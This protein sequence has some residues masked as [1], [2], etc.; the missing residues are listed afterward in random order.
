MTQCTQVYWIKVA[1][2]KSEQKKRIS[3]Q[4]SV[5]WVLHQKK[6]NEFFAFWILQETFS[7][8]MAWVEFVFICKEYIC[9]ILWDNEWCG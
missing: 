7:L 8:Y 5:F 6:H 3:Q 1:E 4:V 2:Q 9:D